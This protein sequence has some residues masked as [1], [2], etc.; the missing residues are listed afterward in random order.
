MTTLR[1]RH[2]INIWPAFV[3]ATAS[4]LLVVVFALLLAIMGHL[5]LS[6]SLTDKEDA[7]IR[8][9]ER[10]DKLSEELSLE[11]AE[12]ARLKETLAIRTASLKETEAVLET[13]RL[14]LAEKEEL[15]KESNLTINEQQSTIAEQLDVIGK[16]QSDIEALTALRDRIEQELQQSIS[17]R[18]D[19]KQKLQ[20]ESE[21]N[22]RNVAQIELLN[23]QLQELRQQLSALTDALDVAEQ[24]I[25]DKQTVIEDL[26]ERLNIALANKAQMLQKYRSEFFGRLRDALEQYPD[27]RI[28]GDRFILP[29][30]L[31]F[32][33]GSAQLGKSG[34]QQVK[35][36]AISLQDIAAVIPDDIDWILRIDGHTDK[37]PING[38]VF[39]SN[40]ELSTARAI[41]IVEEMVKFGIPARRMAATGFAEFHPVDPANTAEAYSKN[42][43]IELKLTSR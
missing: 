14:T 38:P 26:G 6:T 30:E 25:A 11:Q 35:Q 3:D 9:G 5:V 16:L 39:Y 21:L 10:I 20:A 29:T 31:L 7:L 8:L 28:D 34:K 2:P 42:R 1:R 41:S 19:I 18:E 24:D 43:R 12:T 27:I 4:L 22:L 32:E 40:W 36:L 37:R 17:Q 23:R 13:S 33:S 15:L